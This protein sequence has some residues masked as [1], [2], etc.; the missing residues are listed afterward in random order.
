MTITAEQFQTQLGEE[1][2]RLRE[3]KNKSQEQLGAE[4]GIH[5]N[6]LARY[7]AGAD[8]PIMAFIKIC[9]ALGTHGKIV[10]EKIL[11]DAGRRNA[12][13]NGLMEGGK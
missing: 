7:E 1:I 12:E 4:V 5:R 13:A 8:I 9:L 10:L 11:P 3:G 2:R 6:T